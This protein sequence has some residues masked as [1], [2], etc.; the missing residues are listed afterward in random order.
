MRLSCMKSKLKVLLY[1]V[2]KFGI[3]YFGTNR[4]NSKRLR[5]SHALMSGPEYTNFVGIN[6]LK[7]LQ[8]L[9][10]ATTRFF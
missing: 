4:L 3:C 10:A 6:I 9:T 1:V 8:R 5:F 2:L 7:T